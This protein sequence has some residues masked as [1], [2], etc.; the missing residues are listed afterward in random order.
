[1]S[2]LDL[3]DD[4]EQY[5]RLFTDLE[6]WTPYVRHALARH[7]LLEEGAVEHLA[8]RT[9]VPGTCPT[10]I[11]GERWVVKF[12]GRLFDGAA[13]FAAE[14]EAGRLAGG[15]PQI[16]T[17]RLV[18]QGELG[19]GSWPWPY[20][21]FEYI[22]AGSIGEVM[23]HL[24]F[25]ERLRAARDLGEMIRRLHALPLESST[26]FPNNHT[27]HLHLL[28]AQRV[29][30]AER[31]QQWGCL[32]RRLTEQIASFLPPAEALVDAQ[33]PPHLIHADLT[34]DH[35]LGRLE[36]G[37]WTSLA[38]I[39][40]GDAMTGGLP[41]EL[42]ALHLDLFQGDARLL[43][44]FL[45]AYQLPHQQ[46][47][48]LPCKALAAALLHRFNLFEDLREQAA[49]VESLEALAEKVWGNGG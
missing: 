40:F 42:G 19:E 11:A 34:R 43:A 10:F 27:A 41:Y 28:E 16:R 46:R 23:P 31:H 30:A 24:V 22:P 2:N 4:L 21:V 3:M 6:M 15:D 18:A 33:R 45:D 44:A 29:G 32:P 14:R 9:G 37:R 26:V 8:V 17:A 1:M 25:A 35:L 38:L 7:A 13:S 47:A 12:F 36:N 48:G 20:L 5:S 39:D 49:A